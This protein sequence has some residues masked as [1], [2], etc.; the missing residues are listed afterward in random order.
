[1]TLVFKAQESNWTYE[2]SVYFSFITMTT[3]GFGD[4]VP[5]QVK[6][7]IYY[8]GREMKEMSEEV[9]IDEGYTPPVDVTFWARVVKLAI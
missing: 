8:Q 7:F 2:Q 1:M 5:V 4:F 9:M 6:Y 3:I